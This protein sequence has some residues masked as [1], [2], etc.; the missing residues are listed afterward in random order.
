MHLRRRAPEAGCPAARFP[1]CNALYSASATA[2]GPSAR[3]AATR[4]GRPE[5]TFSSQRRIHGD[6]TSRLL[7][8]WKNRCRWRMLHYSFVGKCSIL[9][10][11]T[12]SGLLGLLCKQSWRDCRSPLYS[13]CHGQSR[14][15]RPQWRWSF[16]E[17]SEWL[18]NF[19]ELF[20][21]HYS[22]TSFNLKLNSLFVFSSPS[23]LIFQS[24]AR[25]SIIIRLLN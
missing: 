6:S 2:T 22:W 8:L 18:V 19:L 12:V 15:N 23:S 21:L 9:V 4:V 16:N 5:T 10:D 25:N 11:I 3:Y 20:E 14:R 17:N 1:R 13:T 24:F 7:H